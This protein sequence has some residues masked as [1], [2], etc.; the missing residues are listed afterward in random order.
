[1]RLQSPETTE[2]SKKLCASERETKKQANILV[3]LW[4]CEIPGI[5]IHLYYKK[6]KLNKITSITLTVFNL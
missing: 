1:M 5:F 4:N 6:I 3:Q 2:K